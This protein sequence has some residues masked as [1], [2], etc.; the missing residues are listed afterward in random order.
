MK[1]V[2]EQGMKML[3]KN[4]TEMSGAH[5]KDL[6]WDCLLLVGVVIE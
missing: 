3:P 6:I 1:G 5:R 4:A 2:E